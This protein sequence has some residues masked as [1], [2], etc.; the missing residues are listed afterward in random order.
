[1]G[2]AV[3]FRPEMDALH[4][5]LSKVTRTPEGCW[6]WGGAVSDGH[7]GNGYGYF[8]VKGRTTLVHRFMVERFLDAEIDGLVIDHLCRNRL[9]VNPDHMDPVT[10]VENTLRGNSPPALNA[11][12]LH[13]KAGHPLMGDNLRV[14]VYRDS[15]RGERRTRV[16][17][18]CKKER[19]PL[20]RGGRGNSD[21][22]F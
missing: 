15:R 21:I 12:R 2:G 19:R 10:D 22:P 1:M 6:E 20:S 16:C 9:C 8:K 17:R 3:R 14:S 13:C 7:N 18:T 4:R 5:I 11:R